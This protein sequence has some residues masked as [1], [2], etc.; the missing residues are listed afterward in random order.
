MLMRSRNKRNCKRKSEKK[1]NRQSKIERQRGRGKE[2]TLSLLQGVNVFPNNA[3][4]YYV[5]AGSNTASIRT[6]MAR[7]NPEAASR[8]RATRCSTRTAGE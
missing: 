5:L 3:S 4:T 2:S 1:R 8:R 7:K 6:S